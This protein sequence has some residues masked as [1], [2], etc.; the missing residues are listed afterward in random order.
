MPAIGAQP[1]TDSIAVVAAAAETDRSASIFRIDFA[2]VC[3]TQRLTRRLRV[4]PSVRSSVRRLRRRRRKR[5]GNRRCH[6]SNI[7]SIAAARA[8]AQTSLTLLPFAE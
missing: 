4:R 8:V 6:S 1:P 7:A 5:I 2:F 3:V